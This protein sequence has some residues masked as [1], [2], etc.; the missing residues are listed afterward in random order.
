MHCFNTR[1]GSAAASAN[2][3]RICTALQKFSLL[4]FVASAQKPFNAE[5]VSQLLWT[6]TLLQFFF[7]GLKFTLLLSS[8][9]DTEQPSSVVSPT[10][11]IRRPRPVGRS[12]MC[13]LN[14]LCKQ[15]RDPTSAG[16]VA[17]PPPG[18]LVSLLSHG[19]VK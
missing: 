13:E 8:S 16:V 15:T 12:D 6:T 9:R 19:E 4:L 18:P 1:R 3:E 17:R 10:L 2:R 7:T 5:K 14:Q 11:P